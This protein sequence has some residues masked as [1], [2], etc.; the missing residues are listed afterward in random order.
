MTGAVLERVPWV[1]VNPSIFQI[2]YVK[3]VGILENTKKPLKMRGMGVI[4][5]IEIPNAAPEY[6]CGPF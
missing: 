3:A 5:W 1:P 6:T 4:P 2:S